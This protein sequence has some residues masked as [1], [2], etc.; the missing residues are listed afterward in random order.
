MS[1][2]RILVVDDEADIRTLVREILADEGYEVDVAANAAEARAARS[3]RPPDMILLDIW[4]PDADG[5]TLLREWAEAG[6]LDAPVVMLSGHGTVETAMEATRLGAADFIEKPLSLAKLLQTV[7]QVLA[8]GRGAAGKSARRTLIASNF[9]PFGKSPQ[10]ET[11]R[12]QLR[13]AARHDTPVLLIGEAGSGRE[14]AAR[15]L[16]ALSGRAGGP[17]V[18]FVPAAMQP[19][20]GIAVLCGEA[21]GGERRPGLFAKARGGVLFINEL[22]DLKPETQRM[23]G[24][25]LETGTFQSLGS[26]QPEVLQCRLLASARPDIDTA[27]AAGRLRRD[28]VDRLG[29]LPIHVPALREYRED[30]PEL[31]RYYVDL[32]VDQEGLRYRRISVAA[33]NRLR[34]YPWPGNLRELRNMIRRFLTL[35]DDNEVTLAEVEAALHPIMDGDQPLVKQD[36]LALPLREAREHFERAYLEQQLELSGGKVGKLAERV[37]MERTHLYRKLRSLGI[38]LRSGSED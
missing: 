5:I 19:D 12:E 34:N 15:Y 31:L 21:D 14:T 37:G 23:L 28:L 17:F 27:V 4:M 2:E 10:I 38:E 9:E 3:V 25:V 11:L 35:G 36:L 1:G 16:H 26:G 13:R 20:N 32:L 29:A 33:Q 7:E 6:V 18:N 30:V 24:G 8:R 22:A